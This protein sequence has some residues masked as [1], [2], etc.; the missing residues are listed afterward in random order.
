MERSTCRYYKPFPSLFLLQNCVTDLANNYRSPPLPHLPQTTSRI[1]LPLP[2]P[3]AS[4]PLVEHPT[5]LFALRTCRPGLSCTSI[6][7]L[8]PQMRRPPFDPPKVFLTS[9]QPLLRERYFFFFASRSPPDSCDLGNSCSLG[10]TAL[11]LNSSV[12]LARPPSS[13]VAP[14]RNDLVFVPDYTFLS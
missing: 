12:G 6:P 7:K 8:F 10:F 4:R 9:T 2:F 1:P 11:P 13:T 14:F 5:F 3:A